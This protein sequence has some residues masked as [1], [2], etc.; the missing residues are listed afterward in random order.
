MTWDNWW[1]AKNAFMRKPEGTDTEY[2]GGCHG[3]GCAECRGWGW[4][5]KPDACLL[6]AT[7]RHCGDCAQRTHC[8]REGNAR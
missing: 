6:P 4:L 2:C 1:L 5:M 8:H 7:G 3:E